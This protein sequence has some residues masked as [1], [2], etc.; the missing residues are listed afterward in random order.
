MFFGNGF[1]SPNPFW[2]PYSRLK[3]DYRNGGQQVLPTAYFWRN[4]AYIRCQNFLNTRLGSI[5]CGELIALRTGWSGAHSHCWRSLPDASFYSFVAAM[6]SRHILSTVRV[7]AESTLP[8]SI[9][10]PSR[11]LK[12]ISVLKT[13]LT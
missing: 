8:T 3:Q 6:V 7:P 4:G 2:R 11:M 13:S 9:R 5:G 1:P 12:G 10:K